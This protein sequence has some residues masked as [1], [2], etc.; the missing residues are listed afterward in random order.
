MPPFRGRRPRVH[1]TN[2]VAD[3]ASLSGYSVQQLR[4]LCKQNKIA[5]TGNKTTLLTRLRGSGL[6]TALSTNSARAV[7][8]EQTSQVQNLQDNT[9]ALSRDHAVN[10]ASDSSFSEAQ[11][12]TIRELIQESITAASREIA[13]EAALAAVQVLQPNPPLPAT[14][15]I[16]SQPTSE[17]LKQQQTP[18]LTDVCKHAAPFQDIPSQYI[19]DIQ[20]GEFFE[21]SK[22]LSA[23]DEEDNLLF[24]LDNSVVRV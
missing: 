7:P 19:K 1:K 12:N 20:S 4:N 21:L 8:G 15:S 10:N 24:T 11:L 22:H 18:S 5:S 6:Q 13:N 9:P 17:P 2:A 3:L 16:C 23:L 14:T